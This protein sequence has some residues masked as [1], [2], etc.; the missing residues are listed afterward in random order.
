MDAEV[1]LFLKDADS[2]RPMRLKFIHPGLQ[3]FE[4]VGPASSQ[5]LA[6]AALLR[7]FHSSRTGRE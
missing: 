2:L 4:E 6:D 5:K 1:K 7:S 3:K